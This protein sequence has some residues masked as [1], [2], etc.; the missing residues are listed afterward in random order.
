METGVDEARWTFSVSYNDGV[1]FPHVHGM[2][3][4]PYLVI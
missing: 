3:S 2:Y 1:L 4:F